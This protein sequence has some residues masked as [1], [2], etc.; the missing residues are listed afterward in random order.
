M[1]Y[2]VD[3]LARAAG[4][5]V[6]NVRVYQDRGLLPPPRREGRVG[7]YSEAHLARLRLIGRLLDRGFTFAHITEMLT[8]W[9]QGRDLA[10][11]FGLEEALT[12]PWTDE[13][14]AS[15]S[16]TELR[17]LFGRQ[18]TPGALRRAAGLGLLEPAG[19]GYRARS[20]RLLGV[21]AELVRAGVPLPAVLDL[22]EA[23]AADMTTV[24]G[25]FIHLVLEEVVAPAG[26]DAALGGRSLTE[27]AELVQRLRP[28]A[29]R[30]VDAALA[31]AMED[32]VS[33]LLG[34]A[35]LS[36]VRHPRPDR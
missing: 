7:W 2:R 28:L 32:Q 29:E 30:A 17:R 31:R 20:P 16:V 3:D 4:T 27:L 11:V 10:D 14:P 33:R 34:D 12:R 13:V 26:L 6:R 8:A 18:V 22:A 19:K 25:R 24:A 1:D 35:V 21:G 15:Y 23:L 5:T 9:E 36:Q